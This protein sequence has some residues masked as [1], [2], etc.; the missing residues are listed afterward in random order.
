MKNNRYF[1]VF[2]SILF[3]LISLIMINKI[4]WIAYISFC[5]FIVL[6]VISIIRPK[7]LS[8]PY[9]LWIKFGELLSFII[10]PII[11]LFIYLFIF[12][13]ISI[14][15]KLLRKDLLKLELNQ[16]INT[17]WQKKGGSDE[18]DLKDQF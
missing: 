9:K 13:I 17:Y 18:S 10:N 6:L 16:N 5:M 14:I 3:F 15:F 4:S 12:G 1:G 2:F 11:M 7:L 8:R